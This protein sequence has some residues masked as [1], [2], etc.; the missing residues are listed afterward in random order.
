MS[1]SCWAIKTH[2]SRVP[3]Q[4]SD[5]SIHFYFNIQTTL[6][7]RW[8][9]GIVGPCAETSISNQSIRLSFLFSSTF[10]CLFFPQIH[11]H[12]H[13]YPHTSWHLTAKTR[14]RLFSKVPWILCHFLLELILSVSALRCDTV[15]GVM[16]ICMCVT[17]LLCDNKCTYIPQVQNT[18]EGEIYSC[19][20]LTNCSEMNSED[21]KFCYFC[22]NSLFWLSIHQ[23][24]STWG[25]T[26][27]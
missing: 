19:R 7:E 4:N 6:T 10:F 11:I 15:I 25:F 3:L 13:T 12:T 17:V 5:H 14:F 2:K 27:P 22:S 16:Q 18:P 9:V 23:P 20:H 21:G 24:I 1:F 8:S 26:C